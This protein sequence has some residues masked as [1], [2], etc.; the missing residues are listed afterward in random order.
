MSARRPRCLLAALA[1]LG[2]LALSACGSSHSRVSTGTYAGESGASAPY[3]DVGPLVYQVQLSRQLNQYDTEDSAYLQ[4]LTPA[5]RQLEAGQEWFAVF[6]QVYN[7]GSGAHLAAS[8]PMV[9]ILDTEGN[10]YVPRP[11]PLSNPYAYRGG[12][13]PG[14]GRLP[15]LDTVAANGPTQAALLL[16]KI[17]TVTL[18]NRPIKVRVV[19]P[20]DASASASA[21]LDV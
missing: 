17:Q 2:V 11:L 13:V 7:R 10:L 20:T 3:L 1:L 21:E 19:D 5:E 8:P 16:Y 18:D 15:E 6:I 4:G 14:N 9:T 12:L